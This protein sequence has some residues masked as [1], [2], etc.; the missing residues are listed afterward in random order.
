MSDD[1]PKFIPVR[2]P[3][4]GVLAIGIVLYGLTTS[5]PV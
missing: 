2:S 4:I 1:N 5:N 3:V